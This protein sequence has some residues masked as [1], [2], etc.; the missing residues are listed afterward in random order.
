MAFKFHVLAVRSLAAACLL[1]ATPSHSMNW[2]AI[3]SITPKQ[4][5]DFDNMVPMV[6]GLT[7]CEQQPFRSAHQF[8]WICSDGIQTSSG[9]HNTNIY[10]V[11][12]PGNIGNLLIFTRNFADLSHVRKCGPALLS[13]GRMFDPQN[14]ALRDQG[15]LGAVG[16]R[17][18]LTSLNPDAMS[19]IITEPRPSFDSGSEFEWAVW[20]AVFGLRVSA[21]SFTSVRI[22]GIDPVNANTEAVVAALLSRG[23]TVLSSTEEG[24]VGKI[25]VLTAPIGLPGVSTVKITS[26]LG[27]TA[28]IEYALVDIASYQAFISRLDTEY[29]TSQRRT[30]GRCNVRT[31]TSGMI[32]ITGE[33]CQGEN[34]LIFTN[35]LT[36][37]QIRDALE[38]HDRL[39][40]GENT[41]TGFIDRDN[42]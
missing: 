21:D 17:V 2:C 41:A 25:Q 38:R 14:I 19:L 30:N 9:V 4:L 28:Q 11:R 15:R 24:G 29:G 33:H 7:G 31:W 22:A 5:G 27:H 1:F 26:F 40:R 10:L 20:G 3:N 18:T 39:T 32:L 42:Y 36:S 12:E 16:P 34:R 8:H 37:D 6:A 35:L 23:S 13:E